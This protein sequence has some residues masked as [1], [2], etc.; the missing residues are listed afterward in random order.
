MSR[1]VLR[2]SGLEHHAGAQPAVTFLADMN[3]VFED[4]VVA[5]LRKSLGLSERELDQ[6]SRRHRVYLDALPPA[7]GSVRLRPDLSWWQRDRCLFVADVKYKRLS[8]KGYEHAD[9]YQLLAYLTALGLPEGMLIY[10]I[11]EAAPATFPVPMGGKRL[12][13]YAL[14]IAGTVEQI[15][16][17]V[18]R[19]AEA[20]NAA[21][22]R[23]AGNIGDAVPYSA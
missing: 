22:G 19:L 17:E 16:A 21:V 10:P 23:A 3:Q 15:D 14:P 7:K 4:F 6:N 5:S 11:S 9:L 18:G 2:N 8:A 13:V 20:M 1:L 12:R